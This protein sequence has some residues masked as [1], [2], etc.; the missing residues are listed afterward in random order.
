MRVCTAFCRHSGRLRCWIRHNRAADHRKAQSPCGSCH[1]ACF[2]IA[3]SLRSALA[4]VCIMDST[5]I[6]FADAVG[7]ERLLSSVECSVV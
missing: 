2:C 1:A 3:I 5:R 4:V 7:Q 6:T